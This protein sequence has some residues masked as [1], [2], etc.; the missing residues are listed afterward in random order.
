LYEGGVRVPA[1]VWASKEILKS[2]QRISNQLFHLSDFLPTL[3]AIAGGEPTQ[4]TNIDGVNQW[5]SLRNPE[6]S[7]P[8]QSLLLDIF[9]G[10]SYPQFAAIK[11]N[12]KIVTGLFYNGHPGGNTWYYND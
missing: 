12:Y 11:G 10:F 9:N 8:R 5:D 4:I 3:V 7:S 2:T 6:S 1:F